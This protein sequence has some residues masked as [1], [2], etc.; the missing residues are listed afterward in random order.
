MRGTSLLG[1]ITQHTS[2]LQ[3]FSHGMS[4][5]QSTPPPALMSDVYRILDSHS[6]NHTHQN[7]TLSCSI[8]ALLNDIYRLLEL[9]STQ[10]TEEDRLVPTTDDISFLQQELHDKVSTFQHE[11]AQGILSMIERDASQEMIMLWDEMDHLMNIVSKL[12]IHVAPPAY[13]ES[14]RV[15]EKVKEK[16]PTYDSAMETTHDLDQLLD[17]IDRLSHTAPRLNNQRVCL[18]DTQIKELAAATLSKN[19]ER[20]SRGRLENQCAPLP[21]KTKQQVLQDLVLQIQ[22]SASRSLDNQRV[23][24]S[25]QKQRHIELASI[26]GL[27]SRLEKTR[28]KDQDWISHEEML[29]E[30][31]SRTTD[32]LVKSLNRPA[33][34]R[35]RYSLPAT[36]ERNMFMSSL[37]SRV[38]Q[39]EKQRFVNQDAEFT[40]SSSR[41]LED[42][43]DFD[44][45]LNQIYDS[46]KPQLDNQ[47]ASFSL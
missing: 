19:I 22:T 37:F 21:V 26:H 38:Q 2:V 11:R 28:Y 29:L 30:D 8:A 10:Q 23:V 4:R 40:P 36:K 7:Y 32:L 42:K 34:N 46:A 1:S 44:Q 15:S 12:A 18:T 20:L 25:A 41:T 13:N 24:L 5:S 47:R 16:L 35:Q 14:D 33:Y 43:R 9:N 31:L 45:L 17:A 27:V 3:E 6:A 39:L